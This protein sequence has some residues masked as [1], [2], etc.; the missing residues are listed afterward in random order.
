MVEAVGFQEGVFTGERQLGALIEIVAVA[1]GL[2]H[3]AQADILR[4]EGGDRAGGVAVE[5][6][7]QRNAALRGDHAGDGI[8]GARQLLGVAEIDAV[9]AQGVQLVGQA[10]KQLGIEVGALQT[11]GIDVHQVR[12]FALHGLFG[13]L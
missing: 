2:Q 11:L 10:G 4:V 12:P 9:R 5:R 7:E 6:C 3:V 1:G 8:T 13:A